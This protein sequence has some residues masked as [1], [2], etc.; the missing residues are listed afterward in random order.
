[1]TFGE[2]ITYGRKQKK[3]TQNDLVK[4]VGTSGVIIGKYERNE[5]KPS[6]DTA[7]KIAE[8][9]NVTID[10]LVKDAEYQNIDDATLKRMQ[11]I[12]KLTPEDKSHVYAML[13]AFFAKSKLQSLM[14]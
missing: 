9:L 3:L 13:D 11:N 5:I 1:M 14:I 2:R 8:A 7:A 6:I 4:T 10:Y 12:E